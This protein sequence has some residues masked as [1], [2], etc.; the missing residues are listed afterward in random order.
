MSYIF[1]W[2][3]EDIE[4]IKVDSHDNSQAIW[5][6]EKLFLQEANDNAIISAYRLAG[7]DIKINKELLKILYIVEG[8]DTDLEIGD[9]LLSIDDINITQYEDL[10]EIIKNKNIGDKIN[11]KYLRDNQEKQGYAVVQEIANEKK[12]GFYLMKLFDY[13]VNKKV[14]LKFNNREGGSSAGFMVSLAIYN[15]LTKFDI[16]KGRKIVGTGT[17]DNEGQ[18]GSIGGVK[19]KLSGAVS[20]NADLFFVPEE[21]YEEALQAKKEKKYDITIVP[22]KTLEE[23]VEYLKR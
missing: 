7:E 18:V 1:N 9:T 5:E 11:I 17:I 13:D 19:Y 23:A 4:S 12:A 16:T 2:E 22:V 15:Q 21:N 20:G 14:T 3:R 6:R 8:S 10:Q